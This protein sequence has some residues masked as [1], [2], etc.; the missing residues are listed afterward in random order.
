MK[1]FLPHYTSTV[2]YFLPFHR[3]KVFLSAPHERKKKGAFKWINY[4]LYNMFN[5]KSR[6]YPIDSRFS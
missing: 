6:I 5:L 1:L 2:K 4:K 3:I